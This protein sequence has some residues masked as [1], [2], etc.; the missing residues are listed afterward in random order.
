MQA[1]PF[2]DGANFEAYMCQVLAVELLALSASS[3][4]RFEPDRHVVV[5]FD[6]I[7]CPQG[8]EYIDVDGSDVG[9]RLP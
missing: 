7:V 4:R 1:L 6:A 5:T 3:V 8:W 2:T 9:Q